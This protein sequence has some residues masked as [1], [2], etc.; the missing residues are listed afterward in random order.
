MKPRRL[1]DDCFL[2]DK[3]RL[4]HAEALA[5]LEQRI[6]PVA[7]IE[8]VALERAAGRVLAEDVSSPHNIPGHDNAAVDGYA[9]D[10]RCLAP[11]SDSTLA[12]TMRIPAGA[13]VKDALAPGTAARIF[14]GAPM[15]DGADTVVMQ[16][17]VTVE[18]RGSERFVTVPP[19]LKQGANR[20][21]AGEDVS[22]GD[23]VVKAG[24][25]LRPQELAAI[26]STGKGEISCFAPLRVALV[27]TGDEV[28]RPGAPFRPG[29]VYDSNHYLL[30]ATLE[31]MGAEI[32]DLGVLPDDRAGIREAMEAAARSHDVIVTSGGA[33]RGEEDYIVETIDEIGTLHGWQIAI[34]PGRPLAFGQVGDC[35]FLGLPGN[36]VAVAVCFLIYGRPMLLRL[37]GAAWSAPPRFALPAGF[38]IA[39]KKA[40]RREFMRGFLETGAD[41]CALVRRYP[42]DGSGLISSLTAADGLIELAEETTTV[43]QGD[44]VHFIP[45]TELGLPPR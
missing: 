30:R 3:D 14:T 36:P 4:K 1:L 6:V 5:L 29:Q 13:E 27:S 35:I 16:E 32:T 2:H 24:A 12:V 10:H 38:A 45:F 25:R 7:A 41:G 23:R 19:G 26:A 28:V 18:E 34:K 22:K 17:D 37:Q 42:R 9:F 44:A 39:S 40:G 8:T 11:E 15:P 43:A 31:A 21:L 33:S 20:R